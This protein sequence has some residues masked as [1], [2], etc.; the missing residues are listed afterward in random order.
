[1]RFLPGVGVEDW[2]GIDGGRFGEASDDLR[3]VMGDSWKERERE[4]LVINDGIVW[5]GDDALYRNFR[6][7]LNLGIIILIY[8]SV[9]V[10]S[11]RVVLVFESV[12][13]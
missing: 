13:Q 9:A 11:G 8:V 4:R 10:I 1:M 7:T 12:S 3:S 6:G 2:E 5:D